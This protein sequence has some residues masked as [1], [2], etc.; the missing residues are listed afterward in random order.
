M[1]IKLAKRVFLAVGLVASGAVLSV[2]TSAG[3]ASSDERISDPCLDVVDGSVNG[4]D[5][6]FDNVETDT[7]HRYLQVQVKLASGCTQPTASAYSAHLTLP[8]VGDDLSRNESAGPTKLAKSSDGSWLVTFRFDLGTKVTGGFQ[9]GVS[10]W[11][12]D[13]IDGIHVTTLSPKG[14]VVDRAPDDGN[15]DVCFSC[16]G[17]GTLS[18]FK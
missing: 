10:G 3:A 6:V 5:K 8:A 17:G 12:G 13:T 7:A 11:Y 14:A 9:S 15:A 18:Y 2:V 16:G 4:Y 1:I